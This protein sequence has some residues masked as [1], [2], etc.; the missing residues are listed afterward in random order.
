MIRLFKVFIP[1]SILVLILSEIILVT[2]AF[3]AAVFLLAETEPEVFLF[4]DS[5]FS[6]VLFVVAVI[7]LSLYFLDLYNDLRVGSRIQLFQQVCMAIGVAFIAEALL[8][9]VNRDWILPRWMMIGGSV[10]LLFL[11][12]LWRLLYTTFL[13][14]AMNSRKVLL[15]GD[16]AALDELAKGLE[17]RPELGLQ[18]IGYLS[19][20]PRA[21]GSDMPDS[22]NHLGSLHELK[23]IVAAQKP[24]MIVIGMAERRQRLPVQDLLAFRFSNIEV[25]EIASIYETCFGRVC[26]RELRPSQLIFSES[27]GPNPSSANLQTLYSFLA[28]LIGIIVF[29]PVMLL[30]VLLVRLTSPGPVLY[31]QRR[32]GIGNKVFTVYK[33]RTMYQDAEARTGAVWATKNDPRITPLGRF[34]RKSRLD[35]LPQLFN[36]LKGEMAVAGPRPERPEFVKTLEEQIPFYRQRHFVKPGITGWAQIN[37]KYGD[38]LEDTIKKLEYDLYYIKHLSM[39]LDL[40][41]FFHTVKTML[42]SRGAQ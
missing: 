30:V 36:V 23:A 40:Y 31:R 21:A 28:A 12:P 19:D 24:N 25:L 4:Y 2:S 14:R 38:T 15:F 22:V 42:L 35:E 7:I 39:Q 9:Y 37:Y 20:Y 1:A 10:L 13:L 18:S 17:E 11:L 8:S 34:L 27:L 5:G 29:A 6:R 26:T 3:L 32:V 33:F 41:I 16:S